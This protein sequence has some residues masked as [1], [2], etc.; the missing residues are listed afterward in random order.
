L[1]ANF[2]SSYDAAT[3]RGGSGF[4]IRNDMGQLPRA[5][6]RPCIGLPV[7][8]VEFLDTCD[9]IKHAIVDMGVELLTWGAL[10]ML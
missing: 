1:K 7:I 9:A 2:D 3:T 4:V 5:R 8:M 6:S 10:L